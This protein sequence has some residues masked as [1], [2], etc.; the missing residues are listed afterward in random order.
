MEFACY[1]DWAR[2]PDSANLLFEKAAKESVFFSKP[3]FENL[4]RNGL[5]EGRPLML[6][7][8][9]EGDNL[10]ALLPLYER[11][12]GYCYALRHLYTSL[13]TLLI[14]EGEKQDI[15]S[16][17]ARGLKQLEVLSLQL[18]PVAENDRD[19]LDLQKALESSGFSCERF[20]LFYNWVHRSQGQ[21]FVDYM[22]ARPARVRNTIARKKRK[23]AREHDYRIRLFT[24]DDLPQGLADYHTAY[25]ASWKANEV[26]EAFVNGLADKLSE[27]GWLRLAILY[28]HNKPAAAQLWFVAYGK[29]SIFKLAYDQAWKQYSPGSLLIA[30]LMEYTIDVDR[31]HEID[32]LTGNDAYKQDWMS[33]RR[34]RYRLCCR[35]TSPASQRDASRFGVLGDSL[36]RL[37][38]KL[39]NPH[40]PHSEESGNGT[41]T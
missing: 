14:V 22:A 19:L 40:P 9:L 5:E 15:L 1:S 6:A 30:Y 33:E 27:S 32:F 29:A 4:I 25:N 16:C 13:F 21:T 35:N 38:K 7:C 34:V 41:D 20:F 31:V 3:W 17:L 12:K 37:K 2:L 11:D 39:Y 36:R 28:I 10:L 24:G 23:L 8:V 26:F 18:D